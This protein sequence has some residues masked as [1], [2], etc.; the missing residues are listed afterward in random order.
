MPKIQE[1]DQ[2]FAYKLGTVYKAE[3]QILAM[4]KKMSGEA[5]DPELKQKFDHHRQETEQQIKNL[6]QVFDAIGEKPTTKPAP[7]VDGMKTQHD[8]FIEKQ[9]PAPEILNAFL[10][11]AA[12]ATEHHEI[13]EYE[14]LITMANQMGQE[15]IV[16]LLQENLEQEQHTLEEAKQAVQ[17][18]ARQHSTATVSGIRI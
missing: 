7:V 5:K 11:G 18:L 12:C 8:D 9:K 2:F 3:K 1:P 4:L 14:G 17:R 13:A 6:E 16:A 15:D 10:A